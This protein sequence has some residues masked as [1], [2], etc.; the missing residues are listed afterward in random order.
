MF[1][2]LWTTLARTRQVL[3]DKVEPLKGQGKI[4]EQNFEELAEALI[5]ADVGVKTTEKIIA[6]MK[7]KLTAA[8]AVEF[9]K[10]LKQ[11]LLQLLGDSRAPLNLGFSP[12][13]VMFVGVNG[14]G[15]TTSLA[16]VAY[17]LKS[18]GRQVMMV[19][20]DTFRAAAQEQLQLWSQRLGVPL[21]RG[22]YG[23]DPAAVV[24]DAIRALKARGAQVLLI[25]TAGRVHTNASLMAELEKI[26]RIVSREIP[27][28]P[29]EILLVL[30]A[31]TG[32]NALSQAREFLKFSGITGIFL[33]KLDGTAKGGS[34][35]AI[36]AE[37]NLPIKLVGLGETE[38]DLLIF[39]PEEFV[40]ALLS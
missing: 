33:S 13:V 30:D 18:Q 22:Q 24:F 25:D 34:A 36:T 31:T 29:H 27:G 28:A 32:Q 6:G 26:K 10:C 14:G 21:I 8:S 39:S 17:Y 3:L 4:T 5:L 38:K 9:E 40:D 35:I 19:A 20:A 37:L 23:A 15:K 16:K 7:K 11:Q 1:S 2:R 12:T